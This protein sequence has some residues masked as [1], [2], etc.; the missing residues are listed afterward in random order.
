MWELAG[1]A[2]NVVD[3]LDIDIGEAETRSDESICVLTQIRL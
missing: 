3:R 1:L 2:D